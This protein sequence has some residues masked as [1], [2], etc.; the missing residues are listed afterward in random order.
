MRNLYFLS[1]V[2]LFDVALSGVCVCRRG[3]ELGKKQYQTLGITGDNRGISSQ[4]VSLYPNEALQWHQVMADTDQ[5]RLW[6]E[7]MFCSRSDLAL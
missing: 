6:E 5:V 7:V 4:F 2:R 1:P 3:D